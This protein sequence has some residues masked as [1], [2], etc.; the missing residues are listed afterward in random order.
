M[1]TSGHTKNSKCGPI[2]GNDAVDAQ[3]HV[4]LEK[5]TTSIEEIM[6]SPHILV[7][8][9][10]VLYLGISNTPA[11]IVSAANIH[12]RDHGKTPFS[13][14]QGKFQTKKALEERKTRGE[15]L[16]SLMSEGPSDEEAKVSEALAKIASEH[17]IESVTAIALAYAPC[18]SSN[19]EQLYDNIQALK[20]KLTPQQ[21][22]YLESTKPLDLGFPNNSFIGPDPK[23]TGH[24]T[25]LLASSTSLKFV[26]SPNR[27]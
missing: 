12:A 1:A 27:Q 16:R 22:A 11:W 26:R 19:L 3:F 10:K 20:V 14:Y 6:D 5:I 13:I 18:Q 9:G 25:G 7:E 8:Q 23:L 21:I 15:G 2:R 17:G 4:H 24:T